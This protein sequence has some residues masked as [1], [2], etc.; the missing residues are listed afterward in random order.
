MT[1]LPENPFLI[2]SHE[3]AYR[4]AWSDQ[5]GIHLELSMWSHPTSPHT[6]VADLELQRL[7]AR[8]CI[9]DSGDAWLQRRTKAAHG[10]ATEQRGRNREELR[11]RSGL[12]RGRAFKAKPVFTVEIDRHVMHW[13]GRALKRRIFL[14]STGQ[15]KT[16]TRMRPPARGRPIGVG[17]L[18]ILGS[19]AGWLGQDKQRLGRRPP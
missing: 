1:L 7:V 13:L 18:E 9:V 19:G 15:V 5:R 4:I 3:L 12:P 16:S 10:G 17:A 8:T 11:D 6:D 14:Q 2:Y